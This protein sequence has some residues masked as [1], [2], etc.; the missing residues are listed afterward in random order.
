M[1]K[2]GNSWNVAEPEGYGKVKKND[3]IPGM[4]IE[5]V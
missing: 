1:K 3:Q 5:V 4:K 2:I